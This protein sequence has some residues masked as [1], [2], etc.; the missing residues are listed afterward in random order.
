MLFVIFSIFIYFSIRSKDLNIKILNE[1][2]TKEMLER[3]II[4]LK[5]SIRIRNKEFKRKEEVS[6]HLRQDNIALRNLNTELKSTA[7][8]TV[9][10]AVAEARKDSIKRQRSIL[11]GQATEHLAPYINTN[12]NPKDYKFIGDPIDYIIF[13]G[14]S[15]INNKDDI[16]NKVIF[17]D[18]KTGKSNLNRVQRAVRNAII[19]GRVEFRIYRPEQDIQK[20]SEESKEEI[21]NVQPNE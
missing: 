6:E 7:E 15:Q 21:E 16:I 18:I 14:M 4:K 11:K 5:E 2:E 12:H 8:S 13:D 10:Q 19:D 20:A 17:M 1:K 3:E 9:K